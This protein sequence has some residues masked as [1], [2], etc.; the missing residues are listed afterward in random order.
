MCASGLEST[1]GC[2]LS[3]R[4]SSRTNGIVI[5]IMGTSGVHGDTVHLPTCGFLKTPLASR[6]K[7]MRRVFVVVYYHMYCVVR[8]SV[9]GGGDHTTTQ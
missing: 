2:M 7:S 6:E 1:T 4:H 8:N 3:A 9:G 5:G